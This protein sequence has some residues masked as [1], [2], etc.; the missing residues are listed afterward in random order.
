[1]FSLAT[2]NEVKL[3]GCHGTFKGYEEQIKREGL[4]PGN[5]VGYWGSGIYFY[6]GDDLDSIKRAEQWASSHVERRKKIVSD[7]N[8]DFKTLVVVADISCNKNNFYNLDTPEF[9]IVMAKLGEKARRVTIAKTSSEIDAEDDY[10]KDREQDTSYFTI[11]NKLREEFVNRLVLNAE[12]QNPE[13]DHSCH[14]LCASV[15]MER[16]DVRCLVVRNTDCIRVRKFI[17]FSD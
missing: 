7:K 12:K 14:V 1:M 16:Q 5:G 13:I 15:K 3:C 8:F 6:Q 4:K 10:G 17:S 9:Q 11:L 2:F